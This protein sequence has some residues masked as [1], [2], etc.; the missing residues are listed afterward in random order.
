MSCW[1]SGAT[2]PSSEH[3]RYDLPPKWMQAIVGSICIL[4]ILGS[5]AIIVTYALVKE[6]RSKARELLVHIALMDIT[7]T[8]A[9][10]VGL[11]MPYH[12]HI[13]PESPGNDTEAAHH[14]VY[15]RICRAQAFFSVYGTVSSVLWTLAL[16]VYLYYRTVARDVTVSKRLIKVLYVVCYV[17]PLYVSLW[18]L[19]DHHVGYSYYATSGAGWCFVNDHIK[20]IEILMIYDIWLW[21]GVIILIPLYLT[22]YVHTKHEVCYVCETLVITY[23]LIRYMCMAN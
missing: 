7:Y 15:W 19:L 5:L 22:I 2:E 3:T 17:L 6:I 8:T 21:M 4:S 20:G 18:L 10:L 12:D 11:S 14:E 16:A 13:L 1:T 23:Y 9:N